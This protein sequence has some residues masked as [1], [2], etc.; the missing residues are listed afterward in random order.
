MKRTL[1]SISLFLTGAIALAQPTAG[2][3]SEYN[4]NDATAQDAVGSANGTL[5]GGASL[6]TDRFGNLAAIALDGTDEYIYVAAPAHDFSTTTTVSMWIK[7]DTDAANNNHQLF[8]T[9]GYDIGAISQVAWIDRATNQ[10]EMGAP[11]GIKQYNK[12]S[13]LSL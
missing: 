7:L 4:F 11:G 12:V 13:H 3:I 10:V 8:D 2:L 9:R 1:L 5:V 6:T